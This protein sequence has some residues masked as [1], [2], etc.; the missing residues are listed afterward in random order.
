MSFQK[1]YSAGLDWEIN[2]TLSRAEGNA[3]TSDYHWYVAE[4]ANGYDWQDFNHTYTMPWDQTHNINF[5]LNYIAPSGLGLSMIG[6]YGSGFPY[7]PEDAR[8]RPIDK[9]YSGR[10]PSTSNVDLKL[11]YDLKMKNLNI[12][13]FGDISNA[14]NKAN[15]LAVDNTTGEPDATLDSGQP[16]IYVWKPYYFSPPRHIEIGISVGY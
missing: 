8:A 1:L 16:A 15:V 2:Y 11:Y 3:P 7:T 4:W 9:Q 14:M 5:R 10:M 13:L 12:R 6:S